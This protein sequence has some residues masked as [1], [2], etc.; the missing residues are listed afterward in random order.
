MSLPI[1]N[2][3][4]SVAFNSTKTQKWDTI[5]QKSG[6]GRRKTLSRWPYP[7]WVID[8]DLTK[9]DPDE[10]KYTAG[11][12]AK[13]RGKAGSFLWKDTEDYREENVQIGIGDGET[14]GFQL[15]RNLGDQFVEPVL[16]ILADTL[17][18]MV[19]DE[20]VTVSAIDDDGWIILASAPTVGATVTASFEYYWRVA[21][22]DDDLTWTNLF[23][24]LYNLKSIKLVTVK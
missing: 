23:Y 12:F 22:N 5:I 7:E 24:D 18:V 14:T 2:C 4:P 15:V 19:N 21:F 3:P 20:P 9:L 8:I 6:N 10:Y 13:M 11:F 17:I 16:D 1:F